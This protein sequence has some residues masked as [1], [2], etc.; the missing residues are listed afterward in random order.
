[1]LKNEHVSPGTGISQLLW[2]ADLERWGFGVDM[3]SLF[4]R[5]AWDSTI[6]FDQN[7]GYL[8]FF[9]GIYYPFIGIIIRLCKDPYEP[10]SII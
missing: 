3:V 5:P 7:L 2:F 9:R 1:M 10:I 8:L 4:V 6:C